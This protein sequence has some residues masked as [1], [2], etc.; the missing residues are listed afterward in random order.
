[1]FDWQTEDEEY[2]WDGVPEASPTIAEPRRLPTR[3]ILA[4]VFLMVV[5]GGLLTWQVQRQTAQA[6]ATVESDLL[7]SHELLLET[8]ASGDADLF[9]SLLS[10]R[11]MAWANAQ[12]SLITT[13]GPFSFPELGWT[14][15]PETAVVQDITFAPDLTSGELS[16][17]L[18]YRLPDSGMI[19]LEQTA[20]YRRG[21]ERWL[22][23]PP[24]SAFW[25]E[26]ITSER[27]PNNLRVVYPERDAEPALRLQTAFAETRQTLCAQLAL[28][29]CEALVYVQFDEAATTLESLRRPFYQGNGPYSI[30]LP[31]PTLLGVPSDESSQAEWERAY[32]EL[33]AIAL[34]QQEVGFVCCDH[35]PLSTAMIDFQ[36]YDLGLRPRPIAPEAHVQIWEQRPLPS[37]GQLFNYYT[38]DTVEEMSATDWQL[39]YAAIDFLRFINPDETTVDLLKPLYTAGDSFGQ[40]FLTVFRGGSLNQVGNIADRIDEL[41]QQWAFWALTWGQTAESGE[42]ASEALPNQTV[43]LGCLQL[44]EIFPQTLIRQLALG[45]Q[46]WTTLYEN[47]QRVGVF[48]KP[49][50][51]DDILV[52]LFNER[53]MAEIWQLSTDSIEAIPQGQLF[54]TGL[55]SPNGRFASYLDTQLGGYGM[56]DLPACAAGDC[57][58]IDMT[59]VPIWS[60]NGERLLLHQIEFNINGYQSNGRYWVTGLEG[61]GPPPPSFIISQ[62][63]LLA[64]VPP[65]PIAE[66]G[67][68][69][70]WVD[71]ERYG[72]I[73]A[74]R[75]SLVFVEPD[76]THV[77]YAVNTL[78]DQ[79]EGNVNV[80][81]T[82]EYAAPVH[83]QPHLMFVVA[84]RA[85]VATLFTFDLQSKQFS[86]LVRLPLQLSLSF[87]V[88]PNG[89]YLVV[90]AYDANLLTGAELLLIDLV[91]DERKRLA[92]WTPPNIPPPFGFSVDW[93]PDGEWLAMINGRNLIQIYSMESGQFGR[94]EHTFGQCN[95]IA[96][97]PTLTPVPQE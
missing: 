20:V 96:W 74:D 52:E 53:G 59:G 71:N 36:L 94:I 56:L 55:F 63:D 61:I 32:Q 83:N 3:W 28:A 18:T 91:S 4:A 15:Q 92:Y 31:T 45:S 82:F 93:S 41:D 70:F 87:A 11:N 73:S 33:F 25:G 86:P 77:R 85:G 80:Q 38:A 47:E 69:P 42:L 40:W 58:T 57:Q 54:L 27:T 84:S 48:F 51:Q 97:T 60:P 43:T 64:G 26:R 49:P 23:A 9:R 68:Q 1:M 95:H 19:T 75:L 89:R 44:E 81:P 7:S 66:P 29:S 21:N 76:G 46:T 34:I 6:V 14:W 10:G 79:I 37:L 90:P 88:S 12:Q 22:F 24:G 62:A 13:G 30:F 65:E 35:L 72:F 78:A 17:E 67:Y 5:A 39:L 8:A 2:D 50:Q 16:F